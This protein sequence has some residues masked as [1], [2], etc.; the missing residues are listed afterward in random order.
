MA[1]SGRT[2]YFRLM[3]VRPRPSALGLLFIM[4][5][6]VVPTIAPRVLLVLAVS[7]A[8][9]W[10]HRLYPQHFHDL[11][12]A[13]F[14]LLGLALSIFLGF[15][16]NA[17]YERWWEARKQWGQLIAETRGLVREGITLLPADPALRRRCAY[18]AIAFAHA[19]HNQLRGTESPDLREWLPEGE[20]DRVA[21]HRSY[22]D[23]VLLAQA[24]ELR[25]LLQDRKL[26]DMRYRVFCDRL[27]AMSNIQT[28]CERL[29]S[30]TMP[31]T[32]TLLLH[33]TAWLFCL[34][35]PFGLVTTLGMVTP[36][37][38]AILAYAFFG[39]DALGEELEEPFGVSQNAVPLDALV[40]AIEI[41]ALDSLG[42]TDVPPPLQ[43]REFMLL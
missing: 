19:L 40:R 7:A 10:F 36:L 16:N 6:S 9:A 2:D 13:P 8:V 31:F 39:L 11:T 41:A 21:R 22:A 24:D 23:G 25:A 5:G 26:S 35:L 42:E 15:R 12:P 37:T 29:R 18:R 1:D 38:T 17:S 28:A 32:Y 43:P 14:T 30:T 33:R 27:Q 4:R 20:W 3:I 34:L